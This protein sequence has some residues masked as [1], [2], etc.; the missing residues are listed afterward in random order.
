MKLIKLK[1]KIQITTFSEGCCLLRGYSTRAAELPSNHP[2]RI[3]RVASFQ[4][5]LVAEN[6][7]QLIFHSTVVKLN[8][9]DGN[10]L[11]IL[12]VDFGR[13]GG[14]ASVYHQDVINLYC[15]ESEGVYLQ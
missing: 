2:R 12:N 3:Q 10:L 5:T 4:L 6:R 1:R 9:Q 13:A 11:G 14:Q 8:T 15:N 7:R